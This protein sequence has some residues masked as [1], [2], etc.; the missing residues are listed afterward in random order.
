MVP[1][2]KFYF[3]EEVRQAAMQSLSPLLR[4]AHMA[5]KSGKHLGAD[6]MFVKRMLD[7]IWQPLM[8]AMAKVGSS[9]P[10]CSRSPE[11]R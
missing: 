9:P 11:A 3:H 1:L 6:M 4:C 5:A 7:Y 8:D 2:L 10:S